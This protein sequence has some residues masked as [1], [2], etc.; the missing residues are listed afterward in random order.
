MIKTIRHTG[1]IVKNIE[2]SLIFYRD[3][4][5]FK[6]IKQSLENGIFID[7]MLGLKNVSLTTV[8][9]KIPGSKELIELLEYKEPEGKYIN[10]KINDIGIGHVAFEVFKIDEVY[11]G[12]SKKGVKFL[13]KPY[14]SPDGYAKVCFCCAP[15][16]TYI[17]FVEVTNE[18]K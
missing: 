3:K 15:E 2:K 12:L 4:L 8:K 11:S 5:G 13:S 1:I 17:E 9:M 6:V 14:L 16:G 10:R 18:S 7:N